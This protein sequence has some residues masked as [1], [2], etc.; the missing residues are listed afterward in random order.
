MQ[1]VFE[2]IAIQTMLYNYC[3]AI[4]L[5]LSHLNDK[6]AFVTAVL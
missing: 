6:L 4:V 3:S 1:Q 2:G 5:L